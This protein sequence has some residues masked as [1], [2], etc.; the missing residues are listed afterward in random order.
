MNSREKAFERAK[1][2]AE[3]VARDPEKVKKIID[4]ALHKATAT[5][6]SSQFQEISDKLQALVRM[7]RSWINRDYRIIPWQTIILSIT[8]IVYFVTPFDAIFDFIPFLGFADDV[9]VLTAVLASINHDLDKFMEWE[10]EPV[11]EE[12]PVAGAV[13]ADFE[14]IAEEKKPEA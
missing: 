2:K 8:A 3:N 4:S 11:Q 13:D 1:K 7:L 9:A 10:G 12:A 14:E 5:K 6:T